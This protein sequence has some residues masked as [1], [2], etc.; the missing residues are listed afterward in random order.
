MK[1]FG[2]KGAESK[3]SRHLRVEGGTRLG[4]GG[5]KEKT[6][7]EPTC[8]VKKNQNDWQKATWHQEDETKKRRE[9]LSIH[10]GNQR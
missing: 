7:R 4:K 3:T 6:G 2:G 8:C 9:R 10:A 5:T 1:K